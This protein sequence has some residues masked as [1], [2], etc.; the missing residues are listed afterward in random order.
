MPTKRGQ[1]LPEALAV[2]DAALVKV[3]AEGTHQE[4][5]PRAGR[6]GPIFACVRL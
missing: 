6:T 5:V 2:R 3:L 4:L 1:R